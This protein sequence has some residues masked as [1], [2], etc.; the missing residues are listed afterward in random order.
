VVAAAGNN[1]LPHLLTSCLRL[2]SLSSLKLP[3]NLLNNTLL[4]SNKLTS[5]EC[6]KLALVSVVK[7]KVQ[8]L[9]LVW[10]VVVDF[11]LVLESPVV[12][13]LLRVEELTCE[14]RSCSV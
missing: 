6:S 11:L 10:H 12:A 5:L 1:K 14:E 4:C 13:A 7:L 3:N 9:V 8:T 2:L